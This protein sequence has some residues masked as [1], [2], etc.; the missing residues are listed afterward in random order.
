[1]TD[2]Y[3][4]IVFMH[5]QDKGNAWT[6]LEEHVQWFDQ[7]LNPTDK[8]L[9]GMLA[10]F[11]D[12]GW[13]S[14]LNTIGTDFDP[15]KMAKEFGRINEI[16]EKVHQLK[17]EHFSI[18]KRVRLVTAKTLYPILNNLRGG[19]PGLEATR[20]KNFLVGNDP[21]VRYDTAKVVEAIIRVRHFGSGIPVLRVDWDALLN[22]GT[23][24]HLL[25][26]VVSRIPPYCHELADNHRVNSYLISGQYK[27]PDNDD[28][29][30]WTINDFNTAFATRMF[31]ALVPTE[32]VIKW[33]NDKSRLGRDKEGNIIDGTITEKDLNE[34]TKEG[35]FDKKVM[36]EYYGLE[37]PST[38]LASL[39]S[40]PRESVVS[41]AG[42]VI[43]EGA[44]LDLP[45]FSNFQ[46]NVMWIDDYLKY[47]LHRALG[48]FA[49]VT[50]PVSNDREEIP[51]RY[52]DTV[53]Y[54]DRV[55][56]GQGN[57]RRYTLGEYIPTLFWGILM[58]G[59]INA[60]GGKESTFVATLDR[61]LKRGVFDASDR[62]ELREALIKMAV[63]RINKL[64]R[65][66][67]NL[68]TKVDP[69]FA[70]LWV[71]S[72]EDAIGEVIKGLTLPPNDWLGWGLLDRPLEKFE[73]GEIKNIAEL[74]DP[75][76]RRVLRLINDMCTYIDWALEWPKFVQSVRTIKVGELEFDV[77]YVPRG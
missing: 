68:K 12:P 1:M 54:K 25:D 49:K 61:T 8:K 63:E 45:P 47:E 53:V 65:L 62:D 43:S 77:S 9:Q 55:L 72:G 32:K 66:W 30:S 50:T 67:S 60:S 29:S 38:G 64:I 31:P 48:H 6:A 73:N 26:K 4:Y 22:K 56:G 46:E 34:L 75:L 20:L 21:R 14:L 18:D 36:I 51:C 27:Q 2:D 13:L 57:L 52:P 23:L 39:G 3:N 28:P 42:L 58:D 40:N 69:S 70:S 5:L 37:N 59:W 41:G 71:G 7:C 33:L 44:I 19:K 35:A 74:R 76:R 10:I 16:E 24:P 11:V 15:V 17:K